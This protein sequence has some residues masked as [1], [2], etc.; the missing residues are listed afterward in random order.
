MCLSHT[1]NVNDLIQ[2]A[3]QV[4]ITLCNNFNTSCEQHTTK[5]LMDQRHLASYPHI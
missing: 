5:G 3:K 4:D 1:E 2:T